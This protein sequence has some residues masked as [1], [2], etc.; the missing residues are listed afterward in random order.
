MK[1][2]QWRSTP[3]GGRG[4]RFAWVKTN[5]NPALL[6]EDAQNKVHQY[7]P[8]SAAWYRLLRRSSGKQRSFD[9]VF[10]AATVSFDVQP[11]VTETI[12]EAM[13]LGEAVTQK[14]A[15]P[16]EG[17]VSTYN[18]LVAASTVELDVDTTSEGLVRSCLPIALSAHGM[19]EDMSKFGTEQDSRVGEGA[20]Y[21]TIPSEVKPRII[22]LS[23]KTDNAAV[24]KTP[25]CPL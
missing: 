13:A 4:E 2:S 21:D 24:T 15:A 22:D 6:V 9:A 19:M 25:E 20:V 5:Q 18:R 10:N 12:T 11:A 14:F 23:T 7:S 17:T 16:P 3:R 8:V 1:C